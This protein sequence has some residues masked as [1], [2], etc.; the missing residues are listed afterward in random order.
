M[1]LLGL[2]SSKTLLRP[3]EVRREA[4]RVAGTAEPDHRF[5]DIAAYRD[6][7]IRHLDDSRQVSGYRDRGV[8]VHK[9]R[10]RSRVPAAWR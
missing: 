6:E 7:I 8:A 1:R 4:R 2:H 5:A 10:R 9:A 3:A